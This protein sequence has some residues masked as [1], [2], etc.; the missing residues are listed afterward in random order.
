MAIEIMFL[1]VSL[2]LLISSCESSM[3]DEPIVE[4]PF[5]KIRGNHAEGYYEFHNIP[6]AEPPIGK[7][8]K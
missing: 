4:L 2:S 6:F 7:H 8:K 3:T 1:I 5:G